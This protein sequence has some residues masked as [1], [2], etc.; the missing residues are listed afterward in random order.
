VAQLLSD[1]ALELRGEIRHM[2]LTGAGLAPAMTITQLFDSVAIRI[3]G[4]K[5]RD[6][7]IAINWHFTDSSEQYRMELSNGVLIHFP[8][9]VDHDAD[10]TVTLTK[11]ILPQM[12][13]GSGHLD[14]EHTGDPGVLI[15][16][17]ALTDSPNPDFPI[18]TP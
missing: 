8:T 12:L 15:T 10:L 6:T 14:F 1:G 3:V 16:L 7:R 18:V 9:T 4:A 2:P 13:A 17:L 11:A 5:A